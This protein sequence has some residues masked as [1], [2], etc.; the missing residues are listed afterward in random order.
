MFILFYIYPVSFLT[1]FHISLPGSQYVC[2]SISALRKESIEVGPKRPKHLEKAAAQGLL[3]C[4]SLESK[5]S[6]LTQLQ[7]SLFP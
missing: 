3:S 7:A 2:R 5:I 6:A 1:A 4:L